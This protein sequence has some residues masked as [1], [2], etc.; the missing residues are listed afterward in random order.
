MAAAAGRQA[1]AAA[2]EIVVPVSR[3]F[4]IK[5]LFYTRLCD[6][7]VEHLIIHP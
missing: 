2:S 7:M 1:S 5:Q 6:K 3:N 4:D